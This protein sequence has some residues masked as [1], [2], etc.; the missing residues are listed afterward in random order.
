MLVFYLLRVAESRTTWKMAIQ[1]SCAHCSA[2]IRV[3]DSA[4]GKTGRCPECQAHLLVPQVEI[5]AQDV[6]S[7]AAVP[8]PRQQPTASTQPFPSST[9]VPSSEPQPE[10]PIFDQGPDQSCDSN[11]PS[12]KTAQPSGI[13]RFSRRKRNR[14]GLL[15]P[16]T[17]GSVLIA[18]IGYF[19][20]QPA[21]KL[22]GDLRATPLDAPELE[23]ALI[24]KNSITLPDESVDPVL[25]RLADDPLRINTGVME[26]E[27]RGTRKGI[28]V[29]LRQGFQTRFFRVSIKSLTDL[30]KY[31]DQ[32]AAELS[33]LQQKELAETLKDFF[34][35]WETYFQEGTPENVLLNY[36]DRIALNA[37]VGGLGY[38]LVAV[39][40]N[41]SYRCVCERDRRLYFLLPPNT[42]KFE[43]VGRKLSDDTVLFPGHYTVKVASPK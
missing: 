24:S 5:P 25:D 19:Y 15:I 9:S 1:F 35:K 38:H 43:I 6:Q 32:H 26:T 2:L 14:S 37:L 36:R 7:R 8:S 28:E 30:E 23:P 18:A 39:V 3:P 21:P 33:E 31:Y 20:W 34:L 22:S 10:K 41:K 11:L 12:I 17:F 27:M 13:K 29:S 16:V 4:S 40:G 42:K